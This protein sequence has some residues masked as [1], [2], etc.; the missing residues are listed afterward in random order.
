MVG[1]VT[2]AERRRL[3]GL[4]GERVRQ[5]MD[6]AARIGYAPKKFRT[7]VANE[8]PVEAC[9]RVIML[10]YPADGFTMLWEKKRLDLTA[11]AVVQENPWRVLFDDAV[12]EKARKRLRD[13]GRPDLAT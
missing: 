13:Y 11:E 2:E 5:D 3:E 9:R 12:L 8:G 6:E 4:L 1:A 7:M 10:D